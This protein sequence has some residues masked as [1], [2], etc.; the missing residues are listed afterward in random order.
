MKR[1]FEFYQQYGVEEFYMYDP[2]RGTLRGWLRVGS[3][4]EGISVMTGFVESSARIRFEPGAGP[5]HLTSSAPMA[6]G[7]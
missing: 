1:K 4:L 5:D 7:F 6:S 3:S 2:F